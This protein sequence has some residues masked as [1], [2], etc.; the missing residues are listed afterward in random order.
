MPVNI[1]SINTFALFDTGSEVT[2]ITETFFRHHIQPHVD[3]LQDV[4]QWLTL[5]AANG[6]EIPCVGLLETTVILKGKR[7]DE[8]C[9]LV[10]KDSSDPGTAARKSRV[11]V[12]IGCNLIQ[13]IYGEEK[14]LDKD[15]LKTLSANL[16]TEGL[17]TGL[18]KYEAKVGY[19]ER[20]T[21]EL[22][23]KDTDILGMA[24][25][26]GKNV[27]IPADSGVTIP[28]TTRQMPEGYSVLVE[29]LATHLNTGL[30]IYP[31]YSNVEHG[32]VM[33]QVRNYSKE[34]VVFS[35]P[36]R[37]AK[38]S[39]CEEMLPTISVFEEDHQVTIEVLK[40]Q[41]NEEEKNK[42]SLENLPFEVNMG[43]VQLTPE[44]EEKFVDLLLR[45]QHIFSLHEDDVGKTDRVK[46]RITTTDD[47][48]IKLPDRRV[49][50][51]LIPEVKKQLQM[52]L[53]HGVIKESN[54][55][56]A[57][58]M[59]IVRK[60]CGKIRICIDY[61]ALNLKTIK[62][63]FPL[64][65]IEEAIENLQGA[66]YFCC[67]DLTQGYLQVQIHESDAHKT[68]FRALG[69]LFEFAR[70]PF[71][72]CNS[73]ATFQRLMGKCLGDLFYQ[74]GVIIYLDDIMVFATSIEQM[75]QR[76]EQVFQR[77]EI[78]GLK[79]KPQKCRF[80]ATE[81]NFLGH[82]VSADGISTDQEKI[83][84]VRDYPVPKSWKEVQS[85][86]GLCSYYRRFVKNFA[87]I[88]NPL[89]DM[90]AGHQ[91]NES[92]KQREAS[93][94]WTEKEQRA[95]E[96]LK[97]SLINAPLLA[98]PDFT[99]SFKLEVDASLEG[100]GAILY[101]KQDG[102]FKVIAYASR[103]L[104]ESEKS[105]KN[106]SSMKLELLA[107]YWSI[108]K[109]FKDYLYGRSFTVLTDNN[110]LSHVMEGK[111]TVAEMSW[112]SELA[113]YNFTIQYRSG[114][115]NRSADALSRHPVTEETVL[116]EQLRSVLIEES[117]TR[118][119]LKSEDFIS[120]QRPD[121]QEEQAK[122]SDIQT[123]SDLVRKGNFP[124]TTEK[125][126]LNPRVQK[127][128]RKWKQ[129]CLINGILY[130][131]IQVNGAEVKQFVLPQQWVNRVLVSLHDDFGHQGRDRTFALIQERFY[132]ASMYK[133]ISDHCK[134]CKQCTVAKEPMPKQKTRMCHVIATRPLECLAIDFTVLEKSSSGV[135]NVLV[136]TDIFTKFT[137]AVPCRNQTA[138]TVAKG[139]VDHW[140]F[141]YGIPEK[142]H[143]DRGKCF[144]GKV[145]AELCKLYSIKKTRTSPY[146][147]AGNAQCERYNRSMHNLLRTLSEEQKTKWPEFL[148]QL[149][150]SY[151]CT[152]HTVTGF[153]PYFLLFGRH[154]QLSIDR[155]LGEQTGNDQEDWVKSHRK[156]LEEAYK[157]TNQKIEH[158]A[159]KRRIKHNRKINTRQLEPGDR[160]LCRLRQKGRNKIQNFWQSKPF[161][162]KQKIRDSNAYIV[163]PEDDPEDL[164]TANRVDLLL[165]CGNRELTSSSDD[166]IVPVQTKKK[167]QE[168]K[169]TKKKEAMKNR[170]LKTRRYSSTS[171]SSSSE[172][173]D[174][175]IWSSD[176]YSESDDVPT[177]RRSGRSNKGQH[178]NP[179]H[180][181]RSVLE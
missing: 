145:I 138:H 76:L 70:L 4:S 8:V 28:C 123:L 80:F 25:S 143:S 64:P 2:T 29:P 164:R 12:V 137:I 72:L 24:R 167:H 151:N 55:P 77:L 11:P 92:K 116:P 99:K 3:E 87:R 127:M 176:S 126:L 170:N 22:M 6:I 106:Y 18:A 158:K 168:E 73:P 5:R 75:L 51:Y 154:P 104:K 140:F 169:E 134:K 130:R 95:F 179:Y 23:K 1:A 98:Y 111:K 146:H 91:K 78:N 142:L 33:V 37:I 153:S 96:Q 82:K 172:D 48:P 124:S 90:L 101:Q 181:P 15:F 66:S 136:M 17:A 117:S 32:R 122:D 103:K 63:S 157:I 114:K 65:K 180:L 43:N 110:P 135:E 9:C 47:V 150:F 159:N 41:K 38:V 50:P 35:Q 121:L 62:D 71:G 34:D 94:K 61:R 156:K 40:A 155:L 163:Y 148:P 93:W 26:I 162:I 97:D 133:D 27:V 79:L 100:L 14:E 166:E 149:C 45:Y 105:M 118:N 109:K 31:T 125:K 131:M 178:P 10:V 85:F 161:F 174:L 52:W 89:T 54:S 69:N 39:A 57:S 53:K 36:T 139:L 46:H 141:K 173:S 44:Q 152:P 119:S 129:L 147:P 67:L 56:Y 128:L 84:A 81:V 144:E 112:L 175:V 160:V 7:Y 59:V 42:K 30:V 88:A 115:S 120:T 171:R 132:W 177:L 49:P 20:I 86:I 58:Q 165:C 113:E 68:A 60:K 16:S 107:M 74:G 102:R 83:R 108:T 21:A 19:C 13:R